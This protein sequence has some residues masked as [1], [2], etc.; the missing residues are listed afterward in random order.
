MPALGPQPV[1]TSR[2]YEIELSGGG[3]S[4][5]SLA[6]VFSGDETFAVRLWTGDDQPNLATLTARWA[7]SADAPADQPTRYDGNPTDLSTPYVIL[8]VPASAIG[9]LPPALY[10]LQVLINPETDAVLA[11][12]GL[13]ELTAAPGTAEAPAV[14]CTFDDVR[15][16]APWI[17]QLITQDTS[18]QSDLAEQRALARS[19]IDDAIVAAY[20]P[21]AG[22]GRGG[23][24]YLLATTVGTYE[25][26]PSKWL[27]DQLADGLLMTAG[28][29]GLRLREIAARLTVSIACEG[30]LGKA[31]DE[32]PFQKLGRYNARK[33]EALMGGWVAE[34]DLN[35]DGS[36]DLAINLGVLSF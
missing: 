2:T 1:N 17:G 21:F 11:Y 12:Q 27:R 29:R 35:A 31:S 7:T 3:Q 23:N 19:R 18:L 15:K 25:S 34:I 32:T 16:V 24:S 28:S 20:R 6:G 36:P 9:D 22:R 13:I 4:P 14:Y 30:Q 5:A 26:G 33:A 10:R 8:S